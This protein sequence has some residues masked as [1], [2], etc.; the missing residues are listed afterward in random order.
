MSYQQ[1]DC[2]AMDF[3]E[4]I[5]NVVIDKVHSTRRY[6]TRTN[7]PSRGHITKMLMVHTLKD[8]LP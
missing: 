8:T 6:M 7:T 1:M 4:G 2:R 3:P 5:F